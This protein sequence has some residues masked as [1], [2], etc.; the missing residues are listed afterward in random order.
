MMSSTVGNDLS[1]NAEKLLDAQTR[2]TTGKSILRPSDNIS[3]TGKAISLRSSISQIDQSVTN[4][5]NLNTSLSVTNSA[6]NTMVQSMQQAYSLALSMASSAVPEESRASLSTQ[7][8]NIMNTLTTA[9]NTEFSGNYIFAGSK[10]DTKPFAEN[11]NSDIPTY[12]GDNIQTV[13][14]AS[15]GVYVARNITADTIF[16]IGSS[17]VPGTPD[18]FTTLK[19]LKED[20]ASGDIQSVS[21]QVASVKANLDNVVA[22]RSQVGSRINR[23]ETL[24]NNMLDS[25]VSF[26]QMLSDTEDIDMADA[27]VKLNER[28]NVYQAALS[29][30][31]KVLNLSLANYLN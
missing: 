22:L 8:D 29:T 11:S 23:V 17:S 30:A 15:P 20:I 28:T 21:D 6:M 10:T 9:A 4:A 1:T 7:I 5:D 27:V 3:G 24:K 31:S 13:V 26:T 14:Q 25:K 2:V 19:Q 16:N 18:I 12:N